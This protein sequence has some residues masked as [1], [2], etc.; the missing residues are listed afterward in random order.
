MHRLT[1]LAL[2]TLT[3]CGGDTP[4][5][6]VALAMDDSVT[7][8][9]VSPEELQPPPEAVPASPAP[10]P[11]PARPA[12]TPP[13][14]PATTARPAPAP[15]PPS[16]GVGTELAMTSNV[17]ITTRRNKV[18]DQFTA[19]L[20]AAALD[21]S[22]REVIPAGATVTFRI[23]ELKEAE[24]QNDAGT[25]T[26]RPETVAFGGASYPLAAD[27]TELAIQRQGR[28]VTAGD[29]GKVAAGA[30]AGAILGKIITKKTAGAIAGGAAGAAAGTAIAINSADRDLVIPAGSRIVLA[31]REAFSPN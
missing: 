20:A 28:G 14:P 9:V 12:T 29:A 26:I 18:G 8:A 13:T 11:A 2:F 5:R 3:A 6:E 25:L 19:T 15:A 4:P 16:L 30:A 21:G 31:L 23:L 10:A 1:L 7:P 22:G 17:E 27:V 24:N